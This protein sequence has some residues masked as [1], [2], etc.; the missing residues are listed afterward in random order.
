MLKYLAVAKIL[1]KH[2]P[3]VDSS[4]LHLHYRATFLIFFISSALI[5]AKEFFGSPIE[6][7]T[8][9]TVPPN[10]MNIY[11]FIMST[12]SVP[13]H[14]SKPLGDGVPFPGLGPVDDLENDEIVYHAYYQWV[15]LVF[16]SQAMLFYL[17]RFIW[18]RIE[19]GLFNVV[20]GSLSQPEMEEIKR[21]KQHKVL[22][23]YMIQNLNLHTYYTW[24]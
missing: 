12:F 4:V 2:Q 16:F 5:T 7:L 13:K 17:P 24:G 15:P 22:T 18:K 20:L 1:K 19:G 11:C 3:S 8:K 21:Q 14:F 9:N 6:C 23:R 10:I